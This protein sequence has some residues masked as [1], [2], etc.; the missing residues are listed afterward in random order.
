VADV[1]LIGLIFILAGFVKGVAG[2]GLPTVS[3]ALVAL[4]RPIP[5]AIALMLVPAFVTNVWQGLAGGQL[6]V[7]VPR[8]GVFLACA[9]A[10]TIAAAWHLASVDGRLLSGL[11]GL[12]LLASATLALAAPNLP[13]PR[14]KLERLLAAPMGLVSGIMAGF[15]GS[16]LVPAAPWLQAIRLPREQF[17][18]AYGFCVLLINAS[19]TLALAFSGVITGDIG[20]MSLL[21]LVP[22]FAGMLLGQ[23]LRF[24][25]PEAR[26]RQVVQVLLWFIGAWLALR[27]FRS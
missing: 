7:V 23:R 6:R 10:G 22:A 26:F 27:A 15:T 9:V 13:A 17:V 20:A 21:A 8:I 25:L 16:F 19:L 14:R 18:Q 3:V 2:F 11:L 4:L 12:S 24:S 1:F 5:E